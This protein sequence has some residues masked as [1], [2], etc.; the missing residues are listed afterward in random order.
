MREHRYEI[1]TYW[2]GLNWAYVAEVPE[3]VGCMTDGRKIPKRAVA[4]YA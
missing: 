1:V 3:L 2:S 4:C